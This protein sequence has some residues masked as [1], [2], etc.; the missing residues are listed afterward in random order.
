MK[1]IRIY[2]K[3]LWYSSEPFQNVTKA[4]EAISYHYTAIESPLR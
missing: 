1:C 3:N 2:P 4:L